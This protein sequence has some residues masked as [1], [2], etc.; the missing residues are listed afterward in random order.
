MSAPVATAETAPPLALP[1]PPPLIVKYPPGIQQFEPCDY[2]HRHDQAGDPR[3]WRELFNL[4]NNPPAEKPLI[5]PSCLKSIPNSPYTNGDL[6]LCHVCGWYVCA[7]C[8]TIKVPERIPQHSEKST[9]NPLAMGKCPHCHAGLPPH[10]MFPAHLCL[11]CVGLSML[12]APIQ[13]KVVFGRLMLAG[14]P[15]V[16]FL[17]KYAATTAVSLEVDNCTIVVCPS[18]PRGLSRNLC[19]MVAQFMSHSRSSSTHAFFPSSGP[20]T[21]GR[22]QERRGSRLRD[23]RPRLSQLD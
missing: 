7:S 8:C 22:G 21:T 15:D 23:A 14:I 3:Q 19:A 10:A 16:S 6:Q 20:A 18:L 1:P 2:I 5:C 13:Y 4:A 11:T 12:S 17:P 9:F